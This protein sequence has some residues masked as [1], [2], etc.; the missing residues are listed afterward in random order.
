MES[1]RPK[2]VG[3]IMTREV[4]TLSPEQSIEHLEEAMRLLRF[5]HLPVV[6]GQRLV[7][8]VSHSDVCRSKRPTTAESLMTRELVV[9]HPDTPLI[10]A[11][12]LLVE[13]KLG[14]LPV[15]ENGATLVGIVT[16]AD[17]TRLAVDL[18]EA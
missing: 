7:G 11:G 1:D 16:A 13:R 8:I 10:E 17:F 15:V 14:C 6:A 18:L 12:K 9:V 4:V 5:R 2:F 3:D